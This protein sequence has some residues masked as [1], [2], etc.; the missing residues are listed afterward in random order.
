ML[1]F[2]KRDIPENVRKAG[3]S[4]WYDNLSEK[5][6]IKLKRYADKADP[7]SASAFVVSVMYQAI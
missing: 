4:K 2:G 7:S 3:L 1:G 6:Q 5:D